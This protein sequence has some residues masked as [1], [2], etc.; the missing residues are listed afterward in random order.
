MMESKSRYDA[1]VI[2]SL[3]LFLDMM[4]RVEGVRYFTCEPKFGAFVRPNKVVCGDYPEET[5]D[6][7]DEEM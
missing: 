6:F 2:N 1:M 4:I 5:I 7:S 3:T